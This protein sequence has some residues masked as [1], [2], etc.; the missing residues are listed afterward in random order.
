M[1][2]TEPP[3]ICVYPQPLPV[4]SHQFPSTCSHRL[5]TSKW[6]KELFS[7]WRKALL[8]YKKHSHCKSFSWHAW[9]VLWT[10]F[11]RGKLETKEVYHPSKGCAREIPWFWA[12]LKHAVDSWPEGRSISTAYWWLNKHSLSVRFLTLHNSLALVSFSAPA[13]DAWFVILYFFGH[14]FDELTPRVTLLHLW[15]TQRAAPVNWLKSLCN[16][17]SLSRSEAQPLCSGWRCQQQSGR[18]CKLSGRFLGL[19]GQSLDVRFLFKTQ[20]ISWIYGKSN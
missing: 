8:W 5:C 20:K 1:W 19:F 10:H 13:T 6:T 16:F 11:A 17:S 14:A 2:L 15:P 4:G 18:I 9:H 12:K 7:N 3:S